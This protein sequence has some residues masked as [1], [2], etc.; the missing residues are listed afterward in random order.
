MGPKDAGAKP[1]LSFLRP[2]KA[3]LL[4]YRLMDL[5][6]KEEFCSNTGG[7]FRVC[8]FGKR[9]HLKLC[10]I[11]VCYCVSCAVFVCLCLCLFSMTD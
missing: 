1:H 8:L 10:P 4:F 3:D 11:R 2:E 7:F 5:S 9:K 6:P